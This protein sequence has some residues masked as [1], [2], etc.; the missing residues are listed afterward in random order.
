MNSKN[1]DT[2]SASRISRAAIIT[3]ASAFALITMTGC[4]GSPR[5]NDT[6]LV[7]QSAPGAER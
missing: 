5:A 7:P 2:S 6:L 1:A 3:F 4:F